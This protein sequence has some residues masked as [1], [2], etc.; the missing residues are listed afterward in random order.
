MCLG[1]SDLNTSAPVKEPSPPH[2]T[3]ASM[4]SLMRLYA[5]VCRPSCVL[6]VIDRA[7]PMRVPPYQT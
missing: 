2:T 3:S 5:A 4:P 6:K 1:H 7:V